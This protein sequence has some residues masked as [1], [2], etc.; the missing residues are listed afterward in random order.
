LHTK[1]LSEEEGLKDIDKDA[2]TELDGAPGL[3]AEINKLMG[4]DEAGLEA[5]PEAGLEAGLDSKAE[6]GSDEKVDDMSEIENYNP[7]LNQTNEPNSS[8]YT[9]KNITDQLDGIVK[10]WFKFAVNMKPDS[11]E[12]F[13]AL[14][15]RISEISDIVKEE[16]NA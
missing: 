16:F 4:G 1:L 11:K 8:G 15:E 2:G 5:G 7:K 12:K 10:N 6:I 14:G 9:L 3:D 13:L